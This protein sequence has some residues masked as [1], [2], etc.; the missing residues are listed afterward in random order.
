MKMQDLIN[1]T[2]FEI[3]RRGQNYHENGHVLE[4][5]KSDDTYMATVEGNYGDYTVEIVVDFRG[6]VE[7]HFCNC[8]FDGVICKH[9]AAVALE[10]QDENAIITDEQENIAESWKEFIWKADLK[11]LQNFAIEYGA[12]D[13]NFRHHVRLAFSEPDSVENADNIEYYRNLISGIFDNYEVGGYIDYRAAHGAM[14]DVMSFSQKADNY[15]EKGNHNEVF[16]IAAAMA[17]ECIEAIQ[18]MDDSAG[19]CGGYIFD[20]FELIEKVFYRTENN[21]LKSRIFQWLLKEVKNEDYNN[22][23]VEDALEPLFFGIAKSLARY[24]EAHNFIDERLAEISNKEHW[25]RRYAQTKY[26]EHKINLLQAQN[27]TEAANDI[28]DNN[29]HLQGFRRIRVEELLSKENYQEAVKMIQEGINIANDNGEAGTVQNWK[30][31]LLDVYKKTN[32]EQYSKLSLELFLENPRELNYYKIYKS[33]IPAEQWKDECTKIISKLKGMN[34]GF[35]G[36]GSTYLAQ[37]YIEEHMI[38]DLFQLTAS[39]NDI[40]TLIRYTPHLKSKYNNELIEYYKAAIEIVAEATGRNVYENIVQYLKM[41][42][43]LKGGEIAAE[44]LKNEL[45]NTYKNRP[46]MRDV[47]KQLN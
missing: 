47:F 35:R 43:Q 33:T 42:A 1:Q 22:F 38:D 15:F 46:A 17:T 2:P 30:D 40:H 18:N 39:S 21:D 4:L 16:C 13:Q 32:P 37:I 24:N 34:N 29:M 45:L 11:E 20:A 28:I 10:I 19:E 9:V 27:K 7:D 12:N 23:G 36:V 26:L 5:K 3:L 8:P 31:I 25:M 6:N 44:A 41:M 14:L